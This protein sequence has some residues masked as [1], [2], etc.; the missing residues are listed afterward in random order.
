M[1][2]SPYTANRSEELS[3]WLDVGAIVENMKSFRCAL[4]FRRDPAIPGRLYTVGM[5]RLNVTR[6]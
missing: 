1:A 4:K 6:N 2:S 3:P 5:I